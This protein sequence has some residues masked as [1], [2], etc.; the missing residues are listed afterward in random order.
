MGF[1]SMQ[2]YSIEIFKVQITTDAHEWMSPHF[3]DFQ[4]TLAFEHVVTA[5]TFE[6]FITIGWPFFIPSCFH[7]WR[8]S[9]GS[10]ITWWAY[11]LWCSLTVTL[12]IEGRLWW[13]VLHSLVLPQPLLRGWFVVTLVT[14][15]RIRNS[16]H[17]F[18]RV[19][20]WRVLLP[21]EVF[22]SPPSIPP[23]GGGA[24]LLL[25][26]WACCLTPGV[27]GEGE[28]GTNGNGEVEGL[29]LAG[30]RLAKI[31][32]LR[33]QGGANFGHSSHFGFTSELAKYWS[34]S[35]ACWILPENVILWFSVAL[36][37]I[38][39]MKGAKCPLKGKFGRK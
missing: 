30:Q 37:Y 39:M 16:F 26:P 22:L 13:F 23:Q 24:C 36:I 20:W 17:F 11:L 6:D 9:K 14:G 12:T 4:I 10:W 18:S 38:M 35:C 3:V 15:E 31:Q 29:A 5:C 1:L 32:A 33:K 27:H 25:D 2:E 34:C 19:H 28:V 7:N 8:Y 21:L